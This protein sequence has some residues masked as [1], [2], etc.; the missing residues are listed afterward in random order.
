MVPQGA[1]I[2]CKTKNIFVRDLFDRDDGP[3]DVLAAV[4]PTGVVIDLNR[5]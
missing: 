1:P 5:R 4:I 2:S 3:R